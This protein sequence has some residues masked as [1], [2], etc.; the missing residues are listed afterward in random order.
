MWHEH[1]GHIGFQGLHEI[2][3]PWNSSQMPY[4]PITTK[5]CDECVMAKQQKENAPNKSMTRSSQQNKLM[6]IDNCG[7][8]RYLSLGGSKYFITFTYDYSQKTWTF[9]LP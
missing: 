9:F 1:M 3:R 7:P 8:F 4:I 6:H 2:S 5:I